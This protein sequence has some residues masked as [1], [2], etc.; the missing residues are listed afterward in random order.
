MKKRNINCDRT[1]ASSNIENIWDVVIMHFECI[2]FE[3]GT[4]E[5]DFK[6][7]FVVVEQSVILGASKWLLWTELCTELEIGGDSRQF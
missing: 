1:E 4:E 7:N 2:Y 6:S 5:S 3:L